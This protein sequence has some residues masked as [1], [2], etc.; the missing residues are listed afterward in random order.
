MQLDL[1]LQEFNDIPFPGT[2]WE[3]NDP[4]PTIPAIL[5]H[6]GVQMANYE[7]QPVPNRVRLPLP[8]QPAPQPTDKDQVWVPTEQL[9]TA[10]DCCDWALQASTTIRL[11]HELISGCGQRPVSQPELIH[12]LSCF[13]AQW[14]S[15]QFK[16][17]V[18]VFLFVLSIFVLIGCFHRSGIW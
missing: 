10:Q 2:F 16:Q 11:L 17:D 6:N 9:A 18:W 4:R 5:A 8:G 12:V 7:G 13:T 15:K 14:M 3:P 1:S